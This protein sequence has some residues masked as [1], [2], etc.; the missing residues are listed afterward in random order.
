MKEKPIWKLFLLFCLGAIVAS[1]VGCSAASQAVKR[2][3]DLMQM[4]NYYGATQEYLHAL[5][6]E[7]DH[8]EARIKLC[9][10]AKPSYDQKLAMA[11]GHEMNSNY[12]LALPQ[13]SELSRFLNQLNS[14]NCMNFVPI[15]V[16]L[17]ITEMKSSTSE[18]Y[19][20]EAE[21][22]F[23]KEEYG[24]AIPGYKDALRYNSPY[25]DCT[26]KIAESYYRS[27]IRCETQKAFRD[28]AKNYAESNKT[29]NGYKEATAKTTAIYYSL[30]DYFLK[31]N[32][33][34]NAYNDFSEVNKISPGFNDVALKINESETCA[35]SKIG[36][37]RFDNPTGRDLAGMSVGDFIFDE[38]K[39]TLQNRASKFIRTMERDELVSIVSEQKLGEKGV[40][41]DFATFKKLKGIHYLIFGK[42][43]QVNISRPQ[44]KEERQRT[45]G[46]ESFKCMKRYKNETYETT[47]TREVPVLYSRYTDK[48][49]VSLSG[50]IKV[51]SVATGE[52]IIFQSISS[53][54][55][56][57]VEYADV[58]SDLSSIEI[59]SQLI[60]LTKGRRDLKDEDSLVKD[61]VSE[62]TNDMVN[63][64]LEK[65][66]TAKSVPDP[67]ELKI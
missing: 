63:K 27:A 36:F 28:A 67:T 33:C 5:S 16:S 46:V 25:K 55:S 15:N 21:K 62:I 66:D 47:C 40:T 49:N 39:S 56:D 41:D 32:H 20:K 11:E 19:Y 58:T 1:L 17:K 52:Q 37:I 31:K 51:V 38:I 12:E 29:I 34:R 30:G 24:A 48:I 53:K 2:G 6:L 35:I 57:S 8:K 13:Y 9:Q 4:K 42:L 43:T 61:I 50:S 10:T 60:D 59:P 22:L 18:K 65:I 44:L 14:Y 7:S 3:D 54:R 23:A 64:I 26:E 45:R